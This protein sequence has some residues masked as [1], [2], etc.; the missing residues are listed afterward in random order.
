MRKDMYK[1]IVE[2]P[3][4]GASW[5]PRVKARLDP[6]PDRASVGMRR[7]AQEQ[8]GH[9]KYSKDHLGPL[10]RY[11][12]K[13]RGRRWSDVYSE[14]CATLHPRHTVKQHVLEHIGDFIVI[15]VSIGRDGTWLGHS[16]YGYARPLE[17]CLEA[18]YVDPLDGR[19]KETADYRRSIGLPARRRWPKNPPVDKKRVVIDDVTEFRRLRGIWYR[20]E[21]DSDPSAGRNAR[22]VDVLTRQKV[23][24]GGRHA[25][26]KR[27][28]SGDALKKHGLRNQGRG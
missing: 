24:P 25:A 21:F 3:R 2:Q 18:L 8:T 7:A 13:Q 28:L 12:W 23:W 11:L 6:V 22:V 15:R 19:V 27:Q 16:C 26:V 14:I 17:T 5:A 10:R 20:I 4:G 1:V 9:T